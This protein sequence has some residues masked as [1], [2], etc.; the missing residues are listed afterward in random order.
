MPNSCP[1]CGEYE[2]ITKP[3]VTEMFRDSLYPH[4][5]IVC[6]NCGWTGYADDLGWTDSKDRD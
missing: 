5:D 1:E 6:E 4:N 2:F 3:D